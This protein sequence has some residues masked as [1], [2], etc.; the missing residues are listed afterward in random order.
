MK[1]IIILFCFI[2]LSGCG[3]KPIYLSSETNFSINKIDYQ[4]DLGKTVYNNLKHYQNKNGKKFN[5]DLTIISTKNKVITL[6]D[7]KGDPSSFRLTIIVKNSIYEK[8][9][10][11]AQRE[12]KESFEYNNSSK[13]FE[14]SRYESEIEN[15]M[16][17]KISEEI[18]LSLYEI[19]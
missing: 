3:F 4:G 11:K 8:N 14:L 7:K 10:L 18:V 16:L 15:S 17:N 1:K 13:K 6:K 9:K 19:Q 5:Y 2:L 12:Y